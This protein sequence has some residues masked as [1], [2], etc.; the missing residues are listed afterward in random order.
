MKMPWCKFYARD[1][2]GDAALRLLGYAA[3]GLWADM[4]S[5]MAMS[6]RRGFLI[7]GKKPVTT[8]EELARL[9]SG[10]AREVKQLLNQLESAG[11]LARDGEGV[12][13]SRRMVRECEESARKSAAGR[14]GGN[15]ALFKHEVK[16]KSGA[17]A[18]DSDKPTF[19]KPEGTTTTTK[20]DNANGHKEAAGFSLAEV[21]TA[22]AEAGRPEL[23]QGFFV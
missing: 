16:Q 7:A 13:F 20:R 10:T 12:I 18:H 5:L 2:M 3:R 22:F 23:A 9:T 19:Q 21:Q 4:L 15:P 8:A 17:A 14:Q 6:E 11:V 1:W